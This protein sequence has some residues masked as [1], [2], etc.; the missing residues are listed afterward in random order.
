M[1]IDITGADAYFGEAVHIRSVVWTRL[2]QSRRIAA[3]A[4]AKRL[5]ELFLGDT[6]LDETVTTNADFPRHDAAVYEQALWMLVQMDEETENRELAVKAPAGGA[7]AQNLK[8]IRS[9]A[10]NIAPDALRFLV[11]YPRVVRLVRG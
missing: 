7:F 5:I 1:A 4:H 3:I 9:T 10:G 11:E 8:A 6:S 2:P